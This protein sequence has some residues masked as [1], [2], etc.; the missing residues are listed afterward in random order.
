MCI[1]DHFFSLLNVF[2]VLGE[3]LQISQSCQTTVSDV[4]QASNANSEQN[5]VV[6]MS[7]TDYIRDGLNVIEC[8]EGNVHTF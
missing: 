7:V 3:N 5:T 4:N 6:P 8:A 2:Y 1:H